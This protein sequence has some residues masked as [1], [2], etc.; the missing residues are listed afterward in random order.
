MNFSTQ[1]A[2]FFTH[3]PDFILVIFQGTC[4]NL[5]IWTFSWE[6]I[7]IWPQLFLQVTVLSLVISSLPFKSADSHLKVISLS[8]SRCPYFTLVLSYPR[9]KV[10]Y[11]I[12]L[13]PQVFIQSFDFLVHDTK[14]ILILRQF[15]QPLH[16]IFTQRLLLRFH[17]SFQKGVESINLLKRTNDPLLILS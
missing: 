1:T 3:L 10:A 11:L 9:L 17:R 4:V 16:H 8:L 7:L 15:P 5:D 12:D 13:H 2:I 14:L 6:L